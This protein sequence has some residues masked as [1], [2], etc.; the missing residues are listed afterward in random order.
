MVSYSEIAKYYWANEKPI[1]KY[2]II[3]TFFIYKEFWQEYKKLHDVI[4]YST[5]CQ[6]VI[7]INQRVHKLG[8]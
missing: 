3:G 1:K 5:L 8:N 4:E 7:D 2:T 6:F